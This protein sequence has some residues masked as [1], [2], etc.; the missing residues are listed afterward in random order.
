MLVGKFTAFDLVI[1]IVVSSNG[2]LGGI[3]PACMQGGSGFP[4]LPLSGFLIKH[5]PT[6]KI[7]K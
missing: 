7:L 6:G 2:Q 5:L 4:Y 1:T 3:I